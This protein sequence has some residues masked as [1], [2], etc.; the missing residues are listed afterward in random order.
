MEINLRAFDNPLFEIVIPRV[1]LEKD[2]T[3]LKESQPGLNVVCIHSY[4]CGY[5]I[6]VEYLPGE[7]GTQ[8]DKTV[9][10]RQ[11]LNV[12]ELSDISLAIGLNVAVQSLFGFSCSAHISGDAECSEL[13]QGIS[14]LI[15][16]ASYDHEFRFCKINTKMECRSILYRIYKHG[17]LL[18]ER[19]HSRSGIDS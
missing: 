9:E 16:D 15:Q 6:P 13:C 2:I 12:S 17:I 7:I 11:V 19:I 1:Q 5:F 18:Q 14:G 10:D 3:V 8:I 4:L